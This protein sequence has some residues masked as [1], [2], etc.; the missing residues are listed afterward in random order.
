MSYLTIVAAVILALGASSCASEGMS[1]GSTVAKAPPM[2]PARRI[3]MQDCRRPVV[4]DQGNLH[5]G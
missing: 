5:C 3:N 4:L 2:D 1:Q